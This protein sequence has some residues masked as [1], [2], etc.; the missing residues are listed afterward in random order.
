MKGQLGDELADEAIQPGLGGGRAEDVG[1]RHRRGSPAGEGLAADHVFQRDPGPEREAHVAERP[2]VVA[3]LAGGAVRA[4]DDPAAD[5]QGGGQPGAQVQVDGRVAVRQRTP[6]HLGL[7]RCLGVGG[8][9]DRRAREGGA[10]LPAEGEVTPA[11]DG[12]SQVHP[13]LERDPEGRDP[14]GGQGRAGGRAVQQV[15][16]GLDAP[17]ETGPGAELAAA[18]HRGRAEPGP[19]QAA[20]RGGDLGAAE[21]EP[22]NDGRPEHG[23][24]LG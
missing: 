17:A 8:H 14:D 12:G 9:R 19:V 24:C 15:P 13:V 1:G 16:G 7:G 11:A 2:E 6:A 20:D 22:E 3:D 10:Q 5:D 4:G 18:A 23:A 21:V